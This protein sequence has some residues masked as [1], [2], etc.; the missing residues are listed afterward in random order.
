MAPGPSL[1]L[2]GRLAQGA[3]AALLLPAVLAML[4]DAFE[5]ER[6]SRAIAIWSSWSGLSV[7]AGP[8][9][10]GAL[11]SATSWRAIY[12]L[13]VPCAAL[14]LQLILRSTPASPPAR[15]SVDVA[16]AALAVPAVGGPAY[17]LIQGPE[18][19]WTNPLVLVALAAG[20]AALLAFVAW[21]RRARKPLVPIF[22]FRHRPF[23]ILNV[24][25][26]VLYGA[27]I[28]CG[29]YTVLFLQDRLG[30]APAAA[31]IA[32]SV[33]VMVLFVASGLFGKLADR[34]GTRLFVGAGSVIAGLGMLLLLRIDGTDDLWAVVVPSVLIHGLGLSMLVA[35][36][37]AGV[38][39]AA[40]DD[41]AGTASGINN[42]V[43]RAGSLIGIAVTGVIVSGRFS[44]ILRNALG[45]ESLGPAAAS[46][47]EAARARPFAAGPIGML[48]P[49]EH[50]ILAPLLA[51]ASIDAFR[52][53][54]WVMGGLALLAGTLAFVGLRAASS[55]RYDAEGT[56][57]CPVT[58]G[59][60]HRD[61]CA[62]GSQGGMR[63]GS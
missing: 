22:L 45:G 34:Y 26:F 2:V 30:Y 55:A 16:G 32:A 49:E 50:G 24:V 40:P 51:D 1:L 27:L 23:A 52:A 48:T 33:P 9:V 25:T 20:L 61:A 19:G 5:G 38:M 37:T 11:I 6:R 60:T 3:A 57:G 15:G 36:L 17:A 21:E 28:S 31:G 46:A 58:G 13:E 47:L 41:R 29:T 59:R 44:G 35:P 39:S 54:V 14:V 42:A 63:V 7:I 62:I 8:V 53:G 43:A 56:V 4:N 18:V 12:W 10:G